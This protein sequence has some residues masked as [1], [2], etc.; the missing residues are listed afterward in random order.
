[1]CKFRAWMLAR[2]AQGAIVIFLVYVPIACL[3][4][5]VVDTDDFLTA[6]WGEILYSIVF[7]FLTALAAY[8]LARAKREGDGK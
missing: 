6:P 4:R 7:G 2:P 3:L 1:M 8:L 5:F